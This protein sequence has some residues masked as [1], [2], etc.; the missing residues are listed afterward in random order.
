MMCENR[1]WNWVFYRNQAIMGYSTIF[2]KVIYLNMWSPLLVIFKSTY[3]RGTVMHWSCTWFKNYRQEMLWISHKNN[4]ITMLLLKVAQPFSNFCTN[5]NS[6]DA[7]FLKVWKKES[8]EE[9][10]HHPGAVGEFFPEFQSF[11]D[12][13]EGWL[14]Q[15][16]PLL[17]CLFIKVKDKLT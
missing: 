13:W 3:S 11:A 1:L 17:E 15:Y 12:A 5:L 7:A 8:V 6:K 10:I 14:K 9:W 4:I 16:H 2:D